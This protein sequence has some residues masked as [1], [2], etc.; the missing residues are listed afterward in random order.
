MSTLDWIILVGTLLFIVI[1]GIWKNKRSKGIEGY[2]KGDN[3]VSWWVIGLSVMATQASA[4]T[5]LSTPGQAFE[6][7]MG[8]VQ[9]YFGLPLA[10]VVI[11]MIFIPLYHKQ[12]V[13]TA[14]ELLEK[15]FDKNTRTLT[16]LLFL[17]QRGLAAGITIYAPSIILSAVLGWR[18]NT[19]VLVIGVV[20]T[21]Y[22]VLGGTDAV[23][24]TQK[25]QMFVI[26]A[27]MFFAFYHV[28]NELPK[29]LGLAGALKIAGANGKLQVV[30]F[31]FDLENRY[32][33][34][35]GITGGFFLALAYFGTD[36]SQ[37]Q[38]YLSGSSVRKSQMGLLFNG[39]LK[40]PMQ[41][42]ILMVGVLVYVFYQFNPAPL[43]FNPANQ[44]YLNKGANQ[45]TYA[46]LSEKQQEI[47][48][49]KKELQLGFSQYK[50]LKEKE[51][52]TQQIK[53]LDLAYEDLRT[54]TRQIITVSKQDAETND[55]DYVFIYF[56]L[57]ELPKGL[58][59]LLL[60]VIF[61][62]AM[63]STASELNALGTTTAMD[64][65]GSYNPNLADKNK[66]AMTKG[67]TLLWGIMAILVASYAQLFDNL[68]QLVN[69]IGSIFYG[70]VLGI[71]LV[72]FFIKHIGAKAIFWA[73]ILSQV[74]VIAVFYHVE[75]SYLW[76]N[77]IGSVQVILFA[78][79]FQTL[80]SQKTKRAP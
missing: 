41:F 17:I 7:G 65:Y 23:N 71:F 39:L 62:A 30:D 14:Y 12:K 56:I 19:I 60:A 31:N 42:S 66:V 61:S 69:I 55:K 77:L 48:D 76:L 27:G 49:K 50:N 47:F 79:L 51:I 75:I 72:A 54:K 53:D 63:S 28:L 35:S 59:G 34:W 52:V 43:H 11:C 10:M 18:L 6:D 58:V 73:G 13:Y 57:N 29:G 4:I 67:F 5:F 9:F 37:V 33:F 1:Y 36:Q 44:L 2:I 3:N 24:R 15:R 64:L 8:F 68:I 26:M 32:N 80:L 40:V 20:V 78:L 21:L 45:E 46:K 74:L 22:T 25:L 38:R 70:T 16:A